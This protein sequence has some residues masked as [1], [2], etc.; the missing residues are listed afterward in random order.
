V[1]RLH[2]SSTDVHN[3]VVRLSKHSSRWALWV[4]AAAL[5][6]KSAMPL[7]ASASA[8][9]QGKALAEVCTVYGIAA[10]PGAEHGHPSD[11]DQAPGHG[12][13]HC[14]LT[15]LTVLGTT[16]TPV[17][18]AVAVVLPVVALPIALASRW[19]HDTCATWVARLKHGPPTLS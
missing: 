14:A 2:K 13:D 3:D 15:A 11:H 6:L 4:F 12:A 19:A 1:S 17:L 18:A 16:A 9:M 10:A 5:L 7:L 8:Q